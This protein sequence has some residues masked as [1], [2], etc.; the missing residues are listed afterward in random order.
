MSVSKGATFNKMCKLSQEFPLVAA[1]EGLKI[2]GIWTTVDTIFGTILCFFETVDIMLYLSHYSK[3]N[4]NL[5]DNRR[6]TGKKEV[7]PIVRNMIIKGDITLVISALLCMD[8]TSHI[9][10][11]ITFYVIN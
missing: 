9:L 2:F 6:C 1:Q 8:M 7:L 10:P 4:I 3:K 5:V 11:I